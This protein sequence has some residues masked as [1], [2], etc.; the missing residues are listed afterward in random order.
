MDWPWSSVTGLA[1]DIIDKIWPNQADQ[2]KA[3]AALLAAEQKGQLAELQAT[4]D[5]AKQQLAVNQAEA[6]TTQKGLFGFWIAGWRPGIGWICGFAFGWTYVGQPIAEFA[7]TAAGHPVKLPA[8]DLSDMMPVLL[9]M[10]G[11][12]GMRSFEKSKGVNGR[13]K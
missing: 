6:Q 2:D 1:G 12:G 13:H 3:K 9:G 11:L 10:L 5:N 4:F 8:L 7:L